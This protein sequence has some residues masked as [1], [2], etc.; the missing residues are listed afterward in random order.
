M[1]KLDKEEQRKY[2]YH[3]ATITKDTNLILSSGII[4][5]SYDNFAARIYTGLRNPINGLTVFFAAKV[6]NLK[7]FYTTMTTNVASNIKDS[8]DF[9]ILVYDPE[10]DGYY[11]VTDLYDEGAR[12]EEEILEALDKETG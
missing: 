4:R 12:T 3:R 8:N 2:Y 9:E 1:K 10:D 6:E 11:L 5:G 7:E